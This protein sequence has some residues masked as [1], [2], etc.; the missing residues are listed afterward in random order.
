M[1]AL[2]ASQE[3]SIGWCVPS[4]IFHLHLEEDCLP[5]FGEEF[6]R[7][8]YYLKKKMVYV[9]CQARAAR[10]DVFIPK[11]VAPLQ[12]LVIDIVRVTYLRDPYSSLGRQRPPVRA[13]VEFLEDKRIRW[14]LLG[15]DKWEKVTEEARTW[16]L[17]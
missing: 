4:W 6:A 17:V 8:P 3:I 16:R 12:N 14:E 9:V 1:C 2:Q 10:L 15:G 13:L 11:L 5:H 7:T